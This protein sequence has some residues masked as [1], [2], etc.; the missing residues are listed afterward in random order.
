MTRIS[1]D[2]LFRRTK[3]ILG[4][5]VVCTFVSMFLGLSYV[6]FMTESLSL[7]GPVEDWSKEVVNEGTAWLFSFAVSSLVAIFAVAASLIL[8]I[9][10]WADGKREEMKK[11]EGLSN[12]ST[13]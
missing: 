12:D 6:E 1:K 4:I 5:T 8:W 9:G 7:Y 2:E 11:S 10:W 3:I 13:K